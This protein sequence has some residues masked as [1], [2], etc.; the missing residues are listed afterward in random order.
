MGD[1][2]VFFGEMLMSMYEPEKTKK[3][4]ADFYK[5]IIPFKANAQA[6]LNRAVEMKKEEDKK[7]T[8]IAN[9]NKVAEKFGKNLSERF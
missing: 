5:Y 9:D 4:T 1:L 2:T 7:N 6:F 8:V 3:K